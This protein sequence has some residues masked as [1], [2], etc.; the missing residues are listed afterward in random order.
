MLKVHSLAHSCLCAK[1]K[2]THKPQRF[3]R[4]QLLLTAGSLQHDF[5]EYLI[6][7]EA[8]T[9]LHALKVQLLQQHFRLGIE[10]GQKVTQNLATEG[11]I[12][13]ATMFLPAWC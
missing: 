7:F 10:N 11:G 1:K 13:E 5:F 9:A 12:Y 2:C 4:I 6:D 3:F 8:F